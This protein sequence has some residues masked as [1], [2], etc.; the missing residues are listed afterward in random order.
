MPDPLIALI[1]AG[2]LAG[3]TAL[4]FW[5]ERGLVIRW[6]RSR[7]MNERVLA[8]DALKQIHKSEMRGQVATLDSVAG[9]LQISRDHTA[10][11]L[12]RAEENGLVSVSGKTMVVYGTR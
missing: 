2:L 6:R 11:L 10:E 7:Q 4:L 9:A 3:I 5:P 12:V 1:V 8:E